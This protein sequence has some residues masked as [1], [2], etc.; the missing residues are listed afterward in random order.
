MKIKSIVKSVVVL[1]LAISIFN[2]C[3]GETGS[4]DSNNG[5]SEGGGLSTDNQ[6]QQRKTA[7]KYLY[8]YSIKK[9]GEYAANGASAIFLMMDGIKVDK[10]VVYGGRVNADPFSTPS[11]LIMKTNEK[12]DVKWVKNLQ[13]NDPLYDQYAT[14]Y[15]GTDTIDIVKRLTSNHILLVSTSPDNSHSSALFVT[16]DQNGTLIWQKKLHLVYSAGWSGIHD[17]KINDVALVDNG[18]VAVGSAVLPITYINGNGE[19]KGATYRYATL[20][21]F[22][23][24]GNLLF[25]KAYRK[26]AIAYD[27]EDYNNK[28]CFNPSVKGGICGENEDGNDWEFNFATVLNGSIYVTGT[29]HSNQHGNGLLL[30]KLNEN[31]DIGWA[32]GYFQPNEWIAPMGLESFHGDLFVGT[33]H[34]S[35]DTN[36]L[37]MDIL[38]V[39]P[40]G[41]IVKGK[42]LGESLYYTYFTGLK[43]EGDQLYIGA[44]GVGWTTAFDDQLSPKTTAYLSVGWHTSFIPVNNDLILMGYNGMLP[45]VMQVRKIASSEFNVP[46]TNATDQITISNQSFNDSNLS[47]YHAD[48]AISPDQVRSFTYGN[49]NY[50]YINAPLTIQNGPEV[51]ST[52]VY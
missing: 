13:D 50:L 49:D 42:D 23:I 44:N 24:D 45:E 43:K 39:T 52:K 36:G 48:L 22:D 19:S 30:V 47:Y 11:A 31:G 12:G 33:S 2:G 7:G 41:E 25:A 14:Y 9:S 29:V 35:I 16:I 51:N 37:S 17:L 3:G 28:V 38:K 34:G 15:K 27:L 8:Q 6:N 4:S 26:E 18:F 40:G 21:R 20:L 10:G 32:K 46:D 5:Q 1:A